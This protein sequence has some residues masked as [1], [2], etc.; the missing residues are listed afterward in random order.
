EGFGWIF[1]IPVAIGWIAA[2]MYAPELK[3]V[4][5]Y[6]SLAGLLALVLVYGRSVKAIPLKPLVGVIQVLQGIIG[7]VSDIL[8]YS[9]LMALGLATGIIAFIIN[10]IGAIFRDLIPVIGG[11]VYVLILIGGHT[12]NLAINALGAFIHSGRL[13]FVEFFPKFME[14]GG[15][16]FTP[17]SKKS[18]YIN[19]SQDS[20]G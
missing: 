16:A 15:K 10:T 4:L 12:F 5:G 13:Q 3:T 8:S 6:A 9:R 7:L 2:G 17:L 1:T 19:Y 20:N 11:I 18:T 14:G